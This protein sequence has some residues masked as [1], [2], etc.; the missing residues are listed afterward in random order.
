MSLTN[1]NHLETSEFEWHC[2]TA[3]ARVACEGTKIKDGSGTL[4]VVKKREF[5]NLMSRMYLKHPGSESCLLEQ[6]L[7]QKC[8]LCSTLNILMAFMDIQGVKKRWGKN[9]NAF[10]C[11]LCSSFLLWLC[12]RINATKHDHFT[13]W[14]S[15]W[16]CAWSAK[17]FFFLSFYSLALIFYDQTQRR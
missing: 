3:R 17:V 14:F 6:S 7:S 15:T 5:L 12:T 13:T 11:F 1:W 4:P 8:S 16:F 10:I 2:D 9:E